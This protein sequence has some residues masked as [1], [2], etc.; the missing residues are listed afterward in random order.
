MLTAR[1]ST[2][3]PGSGTW[4]LELMIISP[5]HLMNTY[6]DMFSVKNLIAILEEA[7]TS[8]ISKRAHLKTQ[9]DYYNTD[10]M[11]SFYTNLMEVIER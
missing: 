10:L 6:L 5:N 11:R 3:F 4:K 7:I 9:R 8:K 2:M 1:T